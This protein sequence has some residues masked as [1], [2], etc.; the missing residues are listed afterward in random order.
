MILRIIVHVTKRKSQTFLRPQA[1]QYGKKLQKSQAYFISLWKFKTFMQEQ[2]VEL[3][4]GRLLSEYRRPCV[5]TAD[6]LLLDV[7]KRQI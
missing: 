5:E 2:Y 7:Y 1:G 4:V 3:K 6:V